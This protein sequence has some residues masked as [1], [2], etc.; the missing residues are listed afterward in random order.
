MKVTIYYCVPCRYRPHAESL[1]DKIRSRLGIEAEL[2][3]GT[4]AQ[5]DVFVDGERVASKLG[6]RGAIACAFGVGAFPDQDETVEKIRALRVES[7]PAAPA[8]ATGKEA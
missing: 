3:K 4:W 6:D 7:P 5:F 8:P 2:K 1:A